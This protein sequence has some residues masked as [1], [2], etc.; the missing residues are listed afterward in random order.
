[1]TDALRARKK[2]AHIMEQYLEGIIEKNTEYVTLAPACKITFNGEPC[3]F[4]DNVLWHNTLTIR[5][6]QT[7]FDGEAGGIVF[8]GV[9]S[10]EVLERTE[11]FQTE[12]QSAFV[13]YA[14]VI[15]LKVIDGQIA[16]IEELAWSDRYKYF[17]CLPE[18]IP[19]PDP[20]YDNAVPEEE[21]MTR[22][23]LIEVAESYWQGAFGDLKPRGMMIHP[24]ATRFENGYLVTNHS[25]SMRGDFKWN[26]VLQNGEKGSQICIPEEYKSYP[27]VDPARG[28]VVCFVNMT[29]KYSDTLIL[30]IAEAFLVREGSIKRIVAMYPRLHND[31]GWKK[32]QKT[33]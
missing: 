26:I 27:V 8:F 16:E 24:D 29:F 22:E 28:I 1:M 11:Y 2:L 33:W 9:T 31:G 18:D 14:V 30:R 6:R 3:L 13:S 23:E 4:G 17:Y 10:N 21:R 25:H 19:L 5:K 20:F 7:F 32:T 15:R 12:E